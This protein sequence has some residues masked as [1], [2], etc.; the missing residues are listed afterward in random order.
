MPY[1]NKTKIDQEINSGDIEYGALSLS[2]DEFT[3]AGKVYTNSED[4]DVRSLVRIQFY[5][6]ILV[7]DTISYKWVSAT[8]CSDRYD[9]RENET[10]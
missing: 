8:K 10:L 7:N 4:F 1:T 5:Q 3:L 6:S 2:T 9:V